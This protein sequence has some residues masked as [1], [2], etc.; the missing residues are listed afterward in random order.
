MF[1][2]HSKLSKVI[3]HKFFTIYTIIFV[4]LAV[5]IFTSAG[6]FFLY[7]TG[8]S[9]SSKISMVTNVWDEFETTKREQ[10]YALLS[11]NNLAK[12]LQEYYR[13]PSV[14]NKERV[15][16]CLAS[17]QTSDSGIQYLLMED[18]EDN[19]FHSLNS[20][21]AELLE[22]L[23]ES[24]EY[25]NTKENGGEYL[26]SVKK[27]AVSEMPSIYAC[28]TKCQNIYG[29]TF[30]ICFCYDVRSMVRRIQDAG[31]GLDIVQIYNVYGDELYNNNFYEEENDAGKEEGEKS[32]ESKFSVY[33]ENSV[34]ILGCSFSK[35]GVFCVK[36][37]YNTLVYSVG[38]ICY[39]HLLAEF[40]LLFLGLLM[41]YLI[42]IICAILYIV[43]ANDKMLLP[44]SYLRN[45][46]NEFSIGDE[47]VQLF[48]SEDEIGELSRSFYDMAVNINQQSKE[49]SQK[50]YEKAVTYY[51]LLT[52]QLDPHFIYNTMNIINILARQGAYEDIIKVNT[53]LTRVLRERL[54]TQNTTFEEVGREI[55]ALQQY[56]LIMDYRYHNQVTVE[57]DVDESILEK[58]IPKNILQPL[59]E[60]SYYHG[61]STD[62]GE[63]QGNIEILIYPLENEL[64]IEISD[65]GK[66]FSEKR[67]EE[68]RDNLK[69]A[70][71]HKEK[72]AHIGMENIY[73]RISY[74]YGNHFSMEIQSEEGH[75]STVILTFPLETENSSS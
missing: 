5:L 47:P 39:Q 58:K 62:S 56:Q 63:I 21:S 7:N 3:L 32:E 41:L 20:S 4:I 35:K 36:D 68:I 38:T 9:I 57:Y 52:T 69:H 55:E 70:T 50:E 17:F 10:I 59:M 75:G 1:K 34:H 30:T 6:I 16:L 2:V 45:Q 65:N 19:L 31:E 67:L 13:A 23:K 29:H 51:K 72:E 40:G 66:G 15:N 53:A 48:D 24:K 27:G 74:L 43:P 49:L 61:L 71:L 42:P 22:I 11:E 14:R 12:Y 44:I 28:Y 8:K 18:E 25:R 73:R 26:S 54:N 46:V 64:I 37:S 60:N 33:T